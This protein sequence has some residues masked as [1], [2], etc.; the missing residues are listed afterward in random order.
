[1]A[2]RTGLD[3]ASQLGLGDCRDMTRL[4]DFA[5]CLFTH[6]E[7]GGFEAIIRVKIITL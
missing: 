5:K 1:M 6:C 4:D 3:D 7:H 2:Y